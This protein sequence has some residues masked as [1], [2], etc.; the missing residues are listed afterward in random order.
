MC[1]AVHRSPAHFSDPTTLVCCCCLLL[2][3]IREAPGLRKTR[4]QLNLVTLT[5]Q[6][7]DGDERHGPFLPMRSYEEKAQCDIH[8]SPSPLLKHYP[9]PAHVTGLCT[10]P[11]KQQ[12]R[13]INPCSTGVYAMPA[14]VGMLLCHTRTW[15]GYAKYAMVCSLKRAARDQ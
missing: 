10:P 1:Q 14:E 13:R 3:P 12:R 15:G 6:A 8:L 5:V 9:L 4:N 11:P 7:A 2:W